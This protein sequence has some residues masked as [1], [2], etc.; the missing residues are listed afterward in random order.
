[1]LFFRRIFLHSTRNLAC[2]GDYGK[3]C[4]PSSG[5]YKKT[6]D[7]GKLIFIFSK[8]SQIPMKCIKKQE[9]M[10]MKFLYSPNHKKNKPARNKQKTDADFLIFRTC[11]YHIISHL[12]MCFRFSLSS[13][14]SYCMKCCGVSHRLAP[15]NIQRFH[16]IHIIQLLSLRLSWQ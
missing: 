7:Y 11:S 6:G 5:I 8:N 3:N 14:P 12:Y 1:M 10:D 9:I 16:C 13:H 2:F 15:C 4:C